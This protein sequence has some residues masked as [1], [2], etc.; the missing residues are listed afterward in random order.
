[1]WY[2]TAMNE[3]TQI[4]PQMKDKRRCNVYV[5]GRFCCGLTLETAVK[6]RLKV[7]SVITPERLAEIQLESEKDVA[8]DK[9]LTH[10]SATR[11]TEK[12][13]RDFLSKKGYLP[14]VIDY[15]MEKLRG[16]DFVN[17]EEYAKAYVGF[18]ASKKGERLIRMELKQKGLT[19]ETIDGALQAVDEDEQACVAKKILEKYLRSKEINKETLQKAF[20]YLLG[21][22]FDVD[23]AKSALQ[24]FGATDDD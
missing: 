9:A 10:L 5:D 24:A 6:N 8:F 22:G 3:I 19:D 20:R 21:K 13:I 17:D 4:T 7:G 1:M 11:K 14:A 12:Q 16:Y 2:N 18:T 15:V 23:V